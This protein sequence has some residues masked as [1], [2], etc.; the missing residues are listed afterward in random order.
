MRHVK[1]YDCSSGFG[2][3]IRPK[4]ITQIIH[5]TIF[6]KPK[7]EI[8]KRL[9]AIR[10]KEFKQQ[11]LFAAYDGK[12][13]ED[14]RTIEDEL[15]GRKYPVDKKAIELLKKNK[16]EAI[17]GYSLDEVYS[18]LN[19]VFVYWEDLSYTIV[20][21]PKIVAK[22][23]RVYDLEKTS[24]KYRVKPL[25]I[26]LV[27]RFNQQKQTID[28]TIHVLKELANRLYHFQIVPQV[29]TLTIIN[30]LEKALNEGKI[31]TGGLSIDAHHAIGSIYTNFFLTR[32]TRLLNTVNYW[33]SQI[34]KAFNVFRETA[35]D[36]VNSGEK[37]KKN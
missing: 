19:Q 30:E 37:L 4:I 35:K 17:K 10:K 1:D 33:H 23:D 3:I 12:S 2:G 14:L 11:D 13:I 20:D 29:Y 26:D 31:P 9:E 24:E 15:K 22:W 5:S 18:S 6:D 36:L 16:E 8:E 34:P 32:D 28:D 27:E 7:E 21:F 25:S